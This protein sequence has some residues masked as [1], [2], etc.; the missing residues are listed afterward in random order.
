MR[1]HRLLSGCLRVSML[2]L[3]G[4]A[5]SAGAQTAGTDE[6]TWMGG[7]STLASSFGSP[8]VYGTLGTPAA[9]N[10]PGSREFAGSWTDSAGNLWLFGGLGDNGKAVAF[11]D[12]WEFSP[13]TNQ[14]AWM[15]GSSTESCSSSCGQPGV[16]GR[17]GTPAAGNAPG[18]RWSVTNWIDS[19]GQ[20]WLYGGYG[21]DANGAMGFLNDLWEFNPSTS[22]WTWMGGSSALPITGEGQPPVYGTQGTFAAGNNPGGR[23]AATSWTDS[24]G[25]F[26]LFGGE[27]YYAVGVAGTFNDLWEFN[28]S[29]NQWAWMGGSS[30]AGSNC[31]NGVCQQP[32]MYGTLGTPAAGNVPGSRDFAVAWTDSSGNVFLFGGSIPG[33]YYLDDLW[34]F[35]PS[36]GEWAWMGGGSKLDQPGVYGAL[37]TAST[38]NIP[39]GRCCTVSWTD[40]SGELWLF[41]GQGFDANDNPGCLNDLWEL[42]HSAN[43]W[44][45]MGGSS[46]V[47]AIDES[48]PGV[49]G[50]LGVP[51]PGNIPGGRQDSVSW[52]DKSGNFWLFGGTGADANGNLGN[53]NDLWRYGASATNLPVAAAPTFS[54]PAGSYTSA[55][56]VTISD[57]M[58]G[59]AIVIYYTT[60]GTTP[61]TNSNVYNNGAITV[62]STETLKAFATAIGYSAS[63]VAT[64]TYAMGNA[65]CATPP[66]MNITYYTVAE[67]DQDENQPSVPST[68]F[69]SPGLGINGLPVYNP[70]ATGI[71]GTLAVPKDLLSDGEITWWSPALNNGG[72]GGASDVVDTGA[73]IVSLPFANNAFFPPNGTGANDDNGFQAAILAGTLIAPTA[74]TISFSMAADD[75]AFLYIDGQIA[76][77]NGGIHALQPYSCTTTSTISAGSHTME[78]FYIDLHVVAAALDFSV[79]TSNVCVDPLSNLPAATTTF[80]SASPNPAIVGATVTFSATV[81]SLGGTPQ[82]SVS[83][84][85]GA[86]LIGT[87]TL[88]SGVATYSTGT[89]A[90]GPHNMTAVY[91]GAAG[92]DPS[93]SNTVVEQIA[94]FGISASPGSRSVYTGIAASYTVTI[95]PMSGFNLPVALTCSQLPA[96]TTCSFSPA[97]ITGGSGVSTL[98]V[99]TTAPS[100]AATASGVSPGY[101]VAALAGL[102]LLLVP[103]RLRRYRRGW[104]MLLAILAFLAAGAAITGCS[105]SRSLVG[106]TPVGAQ[107]ITVIGTATNGSQTLAHQT[108]TTLNVDS[109]F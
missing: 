52:T 57:P 74:E 25:N 10:I 27:G 31:P 90:V 6:W 69:V 105:G 26:W 18:G 3:A 1:R 12:L 72:P 73:G 48:Q 29:T 87:G 40:S 92:F 65:N 63:A 83:F 75:S 36:T 84:Y 35:Y 47:S 43:Q 13:S 20:L 9:G 17:L 55:Q 11:N 23:W 70:N 54:P 71:G 21:F 24:N 44:A 8:G 76:C 5:L 88:A 103:K 32:G 80:L 2:A 45:W 39:G 78:L 91:G 61:T 58:P 4:M 96:N 30:T 22:Q 14:W 79:L 99:Q 98:T 109:L 82:G 16:Y 81:S 19:S 7:S 33:I 59:A 104:P 34:E 106:G 64:A 67:L 51:A 107:T 86:T 68:N 108:T 42:N 37:G 60:D 89:L 41:G 15:S 62:S 56:T 93:T 100:Q 50:T 101:R 38:G 53:L 46:A 85:D 49:Y 66:S 95:T 102:F 77:D 94:D 97:S 28:P